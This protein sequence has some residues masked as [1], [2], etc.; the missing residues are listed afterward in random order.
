MRK[1]ILLKLCHK[2]HSEDKNSV[3][4]KEYHN[5]QTQMKL[6][7]K[8]EENS[9]GTLWLVYGIFFRPNFLFWILIS[10]V[11]R[12]TSTLNLVKMAHSPQS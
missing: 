5:I 10:S 3:K 12:F 8:W 2:K 6:V 4:E 7:I 9:F 1:V 11:R